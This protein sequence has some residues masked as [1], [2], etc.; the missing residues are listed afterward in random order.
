MDNKELNE[1]RLQELLTNFLNKDV[2]L[3]NGIAF[4]LV[5][6]ELMFP[7]FKI[8]NKY[9]KWNEISI[10][11]ICYNYYINHFLMVE[12]KNNIK[13]K[14]KLLEA[15]CQVT[16]RAAAFQKYYDVDKIEQAHQLCMKEM[17]SAR[18]S[19]SKSTPMVFLDNPSISRLLIAN[20]FPKNA[21][22]ELVK[23]NSMRFEEMQSETLRYAVSKEFSRFNALEPEAFAK[24]KETP[25]EALSL[26]EIGLHN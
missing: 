8:N 21:N 11:F 24:I 17:Q 20:T 4:E 9:V 13:G 5:C 26:T 23:F 15:F 1:W 10:D 25:F 19:L 22:A 7:S 18:G 12:L 3:L 16:T 14:A 6:W 2:L